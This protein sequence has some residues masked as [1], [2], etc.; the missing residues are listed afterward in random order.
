MS[1]TKSMFTAPSTLPHHNEIYPFIDPNQYTARLRGK[2]VLI[3][4]AGR[5]I[6]RAT[7]Y[8]FAA[9]GASVICVARRQADVAAVASEINNIITNTNTNS[10]STEARFS[11]NNQQQAIPVSADV[12]DPSAP[13]AVLDAAEQHLG[14]RHVD[15]LISCAG[16]TRFNPFE[17]EADDLA[18]W[19]RVF[20]VNLLGAAL[21]ARAVLPGMRARGGGVVLSLASTS[22]TL[23]IPFASAYAASKAALIKWTQDL[24]VELEGSGVRCYT[25]H[26]G[27]VATDLAGQVGAVNMDAVEGNE[28][29]R[30]MMEAN[31]GGIMQESGLAAGT[32]VALVCEDGLFGEGR[33]HGRYVDAEQDFERVLGEVK[34]DDGLG[35]VGRERLYWLKME[36]L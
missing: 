17:S 21:F 28:R 10:N 26:P 20:R 14:S 19:W 33:L 36:E 7:A 11:S 4:G 32:S 31:Q 35:R 18:D 3:T 16:T 24:S 6:G 22:A 29:M 23:D 5:G 8:A 15:V 30:G 27:T 34:E 13:S 2:T 9:A 1:S 25:L 12:T